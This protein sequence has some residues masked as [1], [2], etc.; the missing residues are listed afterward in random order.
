MKGC[1]ELGAV[2]A[3]LGAPK[4]FPVACGVFTAV[5][6]KRWLIENV[7]V[8]CARTDSILL[9]HR[10]GAVFLKACIEICNRQRDTSKIEHFFLPSLCILPKLRRNFQ[11]H[12]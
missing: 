9:L 3:R 7:G 8:S 1:E 11:Y 4:N 6:D 2:G 5:Y 10:F 12:Q